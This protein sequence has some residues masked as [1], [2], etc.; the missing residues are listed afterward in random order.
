MK[1]ILL[2]LAVASLATL[3]H[4]QESPKK[5]LF[6][7]NSYT[8]VNDLP[9]MIKQ[10]GESTRDLMDY[11]EVTSGG[12]S[13][14][15]HCSSSGAIEK[16]GQGGWD[17]VVLQGQSQEPSFPWS[18]F[19]EETYPY[20]CQLAD[21][22]YEK[23]DCAEVIFY[24]TWG[25]K[26]GDSYNAQFFDSLATYEGMDDL[27]CAR[28]TYMARENNASVSPVGKVWRKLRAEHPDIELYQSD[29]SHPSAFGSYAA[30]CA[31]YTL[32]FRKDPTSIATDLSID[33]ATAQTIREVAKTVVYD[34]L[35]QYSCHAFA[36]AK[37][38]DDSL[39][40]HFDC[41]SLSMPETCTWDFGD[42][43]TSTERSISHEFEPGRYTITLVAG[44]ACHPDTIHVEINAVGQEVGPE[45]PDPQN[46]IGNAEET[47]QTEVGIY[48]NP[49]ETY[50]TVKT[51]KRTAI[52][53]VDSRGR[54][55]KRANVSDN[56]PVDIEG[57]PAGMYLVRIDG[58]N[59][60]RLVKTR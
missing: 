18:Q 52:T 8:Y 44:K 23:N 14:S 60:G 29:E 41:L 48:P 56:E 31:F 7:G 9:G 20:A 42:G 37:H 59:A 57:L 51:D 32:I 6:I 36:T 30:A 38:E 49:A 26:N 24:M 40:W 28:Y 22:V 16:I 1:K 50:I 47:Q 3:T 35:Y 5:V 53:I 10:M 13:F 33:A 55:V 21:A 54:V 27:L 45:N 11:E 17:A 25:R 46:G 34:S 2:L 43:Q 15:Q 58:R 4:G 19:A 12:A 39:H